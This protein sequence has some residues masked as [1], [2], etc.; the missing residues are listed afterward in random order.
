[1]F[2]VTVEF[3]ASTDQVDAFV[4]RVQQQARDALDREPD[5][6]TFDV[7]MD[8]ERPRRIF[9]YEV[10]KDE[11]A[12]QAHLESEHFKAFDAEVAPWV[13]EKNVATWRRLNLH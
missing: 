3:I 11:G 12:F 2:V 7:C 5:C 6:R 13:V 4:D 1:M 10:Y 8:P 9:L